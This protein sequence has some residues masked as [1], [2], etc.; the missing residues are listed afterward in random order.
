MKPGPRLPHLTSSPRRQQANRKRRS[1]R[2][3]ARPATELPLA[4]PARDEP[5]Q[6]GRAGGGEVI[7]LVHH[8]TPAHFTGEQEHGGQ[9]ACGAGPFSAAVGVSRRAKACGS[10]AQRLSCPSAFLLTADEVPR[11]PYTTQ[12]AS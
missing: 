10:G 8:L 1:C 9:G 11:W 7:A 2:W 12:A 6:L 4:R 3:L 5:Q